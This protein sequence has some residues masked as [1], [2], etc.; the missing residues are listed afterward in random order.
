M[1]TN[2]WIT[3]QKERFPLLPYCGMALMF[4]FSGL[5]LSSIMRDQA[6]LPDWRTNSCRILNIALTLCPAEDSRRI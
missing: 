2:K 5:C 3:Y 1:A 6:A 4:S